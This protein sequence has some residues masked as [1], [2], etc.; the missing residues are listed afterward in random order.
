MSTGELFTQSIITLVQSYC[1]SIT[2]HILIFFFF[3]MIFVKHYHIS[4]LLL[5]FFTK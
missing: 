4:P 5:P 2:Y 3:D 1:I